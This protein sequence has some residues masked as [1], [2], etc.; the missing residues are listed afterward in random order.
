MWRVTPVNAHKAIDRCLELCVG[1]SVAEGEVGA[2]SARHEPQLVCRRAEQAG[3]FGRI[4]C[5]DRLRQNEERQREHLLRDTY[6]SSQREN[7]F[8]NPPLTIVTRTPVARRADNRFLRARRN[9]LDVGLPQRL[10]LI[11]AW[12]LR[13][14]A[15]AVYRLEG[16]SPRIAASV[17]SVMYVETFGS[18]RADTIRSLRFGSASID[19]DYY[20][21]K[22][23]HRIFPGERIPC[24]SSS[25]L[26]A[27]IIA[28]WSGDIWNG[29]PFSFDLS[30]SM[31]GGDGSATWR[32]HDEC[33][34]DDPFNCV[35]FFGVTG[36]K[37]L[38][39]VAIPCM[40]VNHS[41]L[42][43][44]FRRDGARDIDGLV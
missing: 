1:N 22:P 15:F 19:I 2:G 26:T 24:G 3:M 20:G 27:L 17:V 12:D 10:N 44:V 4:R 34:F 13:V 31:L 33:L 29:E 32:R 38:M 7:R 5:I 11:P 8:E 42:D 30:N 23:V 6:M 14:P 41:L 9:S 21:G 37:I 35:K 18:R 16:M 25:R 40:T 39:R 28:I 43:S 36:E